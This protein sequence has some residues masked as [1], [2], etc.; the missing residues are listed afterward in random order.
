MLIDVHAMPVLKELVAYLV[1]ERLYKEMATL[2]DS[3]VTEGRRT[4]R[5]VLV[6]D[7]AHN[8]LARRTCSF[9]VSSERVA[10]RG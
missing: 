3:P 10:R 7:E 1:I 5:T 4:I 2:P 6:I 9:S 8:T